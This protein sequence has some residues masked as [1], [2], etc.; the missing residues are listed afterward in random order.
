MN[1]TINYFLLEK[2]FSNNKTD[3]ELKSEFWKG[4]QQFLDDLKKYGENIIDFLK[5]KLNVDS[6]YYCKHFYFNKINFPKLNR[7]LLYKKKN[8]NDFIAIK[9]NFDRISFFDLENK[10]EITH[11]NYTDYI[12][13][14]YKYS[15]ILCFNKQKRQYRQVFDSPE[16]VGNKK[17]INLNFENKMAFNIENK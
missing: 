17:K 12:D 10:D 13:I 11:K 4:L 2:E 1:Y 6:I 7:I 9:N 16:V 5:Q 14:N 8:C 15:Y 3:D